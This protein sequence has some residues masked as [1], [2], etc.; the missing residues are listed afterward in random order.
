M[1]DKYSYYMSL[2]GP[3]ADVDKLTER[4]RNCP[5]VPE[6]LVPHYFLD[7]PDYDG[8]VTRTFQID[9]DV[10]AIDEW[11]SSTEDVSTLAMTA[12]DVEII[13]HT[14]NLNNAL[15]EYME[16]WQHGKYACD[17]VKLAINSEDEMRELL[18]NQE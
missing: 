1:Y 6:E 14:V 15:E 10:G 4:F 18:I 8:P 3:K 17:K 2:T 7:D 13:L 16:I 5:D 11:T 12:P 9:P